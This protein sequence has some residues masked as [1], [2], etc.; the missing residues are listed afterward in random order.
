MES[1]IAT[2]IDRY[3]VAD[4][5]SVPSPALL[6]YPKLI[7]A[8]IAQAVHIAGSAG[9]LRPHVKTHKTHEIV[10]LELDAGITK[11]KCATI[12]EAE[13]LADAGAPDVLISYPL[14]GPNAGRFAEL[15]AKFPGTK[16][17]TVI[18]DPSAA[19]ALSAALADHKIVAEVL[20]DIDC[21]QHRT[22]ITP[23]PA[24]ADLY[25]L[26][27]TLPGLKPVGF[28]IYDGHNHQPEL[29]QRQS[30][31]AAMLK[32]IL[33]LR[34]DLESA[35]LDVSAFICGGTPTFSVFATL[36]IPGLE[37]SPGT[38]VLHDVGYGGKYPD[39]SGFVPAA[40]LLTRVVSKPTPTRLTFDL[41]TKAVASDPPAGKRCRLPEIPDAEHVGHNEEHLV[42]ETPNAGRFRVGDVAYAFPVHIC[43]TCA[44]HRSA[45]IVED[46][47][48]V[49][50]WPI[51]GR[52]RKLTV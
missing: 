42:I 29:T 23:G 14:V 52:D 48:I 43:P 17:S 18:D 50:E 27:D 41:G 2:S 28:H 9:R 12:A 40:A 15:I 36:D 3:R 8:N 5:S 4:P 31:V 10:R 22:G 13:L 39:M 44:L 37:L 34:S 21:G 32:P 16:F 24:A 51:V 35:G 45:L 7:R 26:A 25:R 20:L 47:E 19:E 30:S 11:H 38:F 1:A 46:G 6:F 33:K 49:G